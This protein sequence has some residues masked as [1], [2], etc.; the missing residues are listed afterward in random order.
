[1][2][3]LR[4]KEIKRHG[5]P[6]LVVRSGLEVKHKLF[7][8]QCINTPTFSLVRCIVDGTMGESTA[9]MELFT[10]YSSGYTIFL[11]TPPSTTTSVPD[12]PSLSLK[13]CT[14]LSTSST[15]PTRP[16]KCHA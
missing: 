15:L 16:V 8:Q 14:A 4:D 11:V 13:Y 3:V 7:V 6:S 5:S 2:N 12:T 10:T 9:F 1:M